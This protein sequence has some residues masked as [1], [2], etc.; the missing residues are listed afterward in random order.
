[1][2]RRFTERVTAAVLGDHSSA[3]TE[4]KIR[5]LQAMGF[6]ERNARSALAQA[7]GDIDNA[8]VLLLRSPSLPAPFR[9]PT[10]SNSIDEAMR[11]AMEESLQTEE[12]RLYRQAQEASLQTPN[13]VPRKPQPPNKATPPNR[14]TT[15]AANKAAQAALA[16]ST[17]PP[18]RNKNSR[19][20][21][22]EHHPDVKVPTKLEDKSKEEQIL[23]NVNR[24][25]GHPS[26]VDTLY[27]ALTALRSD[28]NNPKF[29]RIDKSNPGYQRSLA[30]APGAEALL[31]VMN[32]T[33][34]GT[35]LV[36]DRSRVDP[37]LLFLGISALED[38]RNSVEYLEAKRQIQFTNELKEIHMQVNSSEQEALKR[39]SL[40]AKCPSEPPGGRGALVQVGF[41]EEIIK[42]RFDGDDVLQDVVNWLGGHGSV[43]PDKL[44][45]REWCLVDKNR[46]PISPID[47]QF[48]LDK[49]LQYV[50]FWP[51]GKLEIRPS[52]V[53]WLDG[54][55]RS[56]LVGSSRG[57]GAA[58]SDTLR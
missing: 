10:A 2:F 23:R 17:N 53:S 5:V 6:E 31:L 13:A 38:A 30:V 57:L 32:F 11:N 14:Q 42:R 19:S 40:I 48:N 24:V 21:I 41:G 29:R 44:L 12:Q 55:D 34:V 20:P 39:A 58:P 7:N 36:L 47:V 4:D 51:S 9:A 8:A 3:E 18:N 22:Q 28:P 52:P 54:T 56:S 1:M 35:T 27:K 37:A 43:I 49:T 26:A 25:K 15:A 33:E 16:R 46:F 50:G 45:T